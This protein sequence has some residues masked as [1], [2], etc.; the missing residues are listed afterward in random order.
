[1]TKMQKRWTIRPHKAMP[2]APLELA[3][4]LERFEASPRPALRKRLVHAV[5][6]EAGR[7][8]TLRG[9][10]K[11]SK[12]KSLAKYADHIPYYQLPAAAQKVLAKATVKAG[13]TL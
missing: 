10:A 11:L 7:A 4:R 2:A 6:L 1:M 8:L 3:E 13:N 9:A 12:L 5:N